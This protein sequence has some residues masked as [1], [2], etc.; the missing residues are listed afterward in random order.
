MIAGDAAPAAR[1]QALT[2][3]GVAVLRVM[4]DAA[5]H[6][7]LGRALRALAARGIMRILSEGGPTV[8][9]R[10]IAEGFADTIHLFTSRAPLGRAGVA[11]ID[12]VG[13]ARLADPGLY[14]LAQ[15]GI[16]GIDRLRRYER[17][18]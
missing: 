16:V 1:E 7:D 8:A 14:R 15:D 9:G 18:L 12:A 5:G 4:A 17:V 3:A 10:L 6:V 13:R 11:A 2:E